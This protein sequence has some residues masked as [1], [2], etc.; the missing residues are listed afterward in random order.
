MGK[1]DDVLNSLSFQ[2][3]SLGLS[4][5]ILICMFIFF[6]L[7]A[8]FGLLL[9]RQT[10]LPLNSVGKHYL[11]VEKSFKNGKESP[12]AVEDLP[13]TYEEDKSKL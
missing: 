1:G 11:K 3:E 4:I 9:T 10:Y 6:I 8:I 13:L 12:E 2:N 7:L 5:T